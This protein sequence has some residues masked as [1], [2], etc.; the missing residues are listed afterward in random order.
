MKLLVVA[1]CLCIGL[2]S[3]MPKTDI[4]EAEETSPEVFKKLERF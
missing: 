3:S 1:I 2:A 4:E